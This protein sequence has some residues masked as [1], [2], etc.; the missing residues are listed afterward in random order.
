MSPRGILDVLYHYH[1]R[2]ADKRSAVHRG[3]FAAVRLAVLR[4]YRWLGYC[5]VATLCLAAAVSPACAV[6]QPN[7]RL[8]NRIPAQHPF[9]LG[10][11]VGC[12]QAAMSSTDDWYR[13]GGVSPSIS[14]VTSD[15][16]PYVA[17]AFGSGRYELVAGYTQSND[18]ATRNGLNHG[19]MKV[20]D[21]GS[22]LVQD[23][24]EQQL[25]PGSSTT[26]SYSGGFWGG[27][28]T[29]SGG[30]DMLHALTSDRDVTSVTVPTAYR[31]PPEANCPGGYYASFYGIRTWLSL[32]AVSQTASGTWVSSTVHFLQRRD[33]LCERDEWLIT[34]GSKVTTYYPDLQADYEGLYVMHWNVGKP[35]AAD[36]I[37]F[38]VIGGG[39]E[40]VST[41][42][43][44]V[45]DEWVQYLASMTATDAATM[46]AEWSPYV[47]PA[48]YSPYVEGSTQ[49]AS[50]DATSTGWIDLLTGGRLED[51]ID[52]AYGGVRDFVD[53][54]SGLFFFL[55]PWRRLDGS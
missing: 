41:P 44:A 45:A 9:T 37:G 4:R 10:P 33:L 52:A 53:S 50:V 3:R 55:E 46:A 30:F 42:G 5:G 31:D 20:Y 14:W 34:R 38:A 36:Y 8:L 2:W 22:T 43:N 11:F 47:L 48:E 16:V 51:L 25:Q 17:M 13:F 12:D 7:M 29:A 24:V 28:V 18:E 6:D 40:H 26:F 19:W 1:H 15:A 49:P 39:V 35:I 32:V 54:L 23:N 21:N 27:S